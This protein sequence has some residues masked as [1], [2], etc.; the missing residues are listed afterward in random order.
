VADA[1]ASKGSSSFL[2][3]RTKKLLPVAGGTALAL[4]N[5]L[6]DEIGKVAWS[7]FSKKNCFTSARRTQLAL[8]IHC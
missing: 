5:R 3:K 4:L 2:K 6:L 1:G 8:A 7:F